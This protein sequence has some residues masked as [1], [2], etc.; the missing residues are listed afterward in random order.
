MSGTIHDLGYKRYL[1]ARLASST[2]WLVVTRNHIAHAW[3]TWWRFKSTLGL[4]VIVTVIAGG[5]MFLLQDKAIKGV[6]LPSGIAATLTDGALP[7]SIQWYSRVAFLL[8]LTIG[9]R[10]VAGDMQSGAFT[11]YFARSVRP[12]D[13]VLGKVFGQIALVGM[14]YMLGPLLLA[15]ARLGLA[16]STDDLWRLL[17]V[18]PKALAIGALGTLAFACVPLGFSALVQ[19]PRYAMAMWA[20]YYLIVGGMAWVLSRLTDSG[21]AALDIAAALDSVA[22]WLFDLELVWGRAKRI[23]PYMALASLLAHAGVAVMLVVWQVRRAHL[24]GI[25]G[26]S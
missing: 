1:G 10:V 9:A 8:S 21:I 5:V 20:A 13:Y 2:R 17:P 7:R 15:I 22:F 4:A 25:G 11:F 23:D 14:I 12:R 19:N 24:R 3:K 6:V 16:D 26:A 18:L